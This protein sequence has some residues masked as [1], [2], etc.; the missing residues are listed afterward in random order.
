ML[1]LITAALRKPISVIVILIAIVFFSI[2]AIQKSAVDI[3][4]KLGT[5]TI[6]VAQ[7]YGGLSPQQMEGFI[8][9]YYEYHFLYITG[10]K[11]VDSKSVQGVA[12]IKLQFHEGTDMANAMA[13]V[14]SYVNRARSFM[15]PGTLPPFVMRYDAGSVPVGQLALSSETRSLNDIQDLALFKVRPMFSSLP[16]VSAPPPFGGNQRT[17]VIKA[18]PERMRSY[19]LA[20]EELITAIAKSNTIS[21]AGN[22]RVGDMTLI[23]PS[24]SVVDNFKELE[25]T[26]LKLGAGASIY[27]RDVA[28]VE[29]GAD[30]TTGYA[31]INGKRAV[32]IPVTKR[33]DASTWDVVR[34]IKKALPDMQAAV[35]PDIKVSYEFDQ[36]G[37]VINS[38]KSLL[39]EAGLGALLTGLMVFFFLGDVRSAVI[40][41]L[42]IPLALL[43]SV[44]F[45]YLGGQTINIMTLGGLAL[46][47]GI[48]VDE[49]TVT[50]ENIHRYLEMGKP[51]AR[52]VFD[53]CKEIA[54]P[55]LLILFSVLAVFVPSL[56]M[57]GV[58]RAMFLPLSLAVGF[59]M[60]SSFIL[61]QTFV[62]VI[63]N[64]ILNKEFHNNKRFEKF[65]ERFTNVSSRLTSIG[66]ILLLIYLMTTIIFSFFIYNSIGK[67]IFPKIDAGQLQL[68]LRMPSG[69]RIERTE[70]ATKKVLN[71]IDSIAGKQNV[72]ITSSFV[73]LQPQSYAINSIFLWTSG[74]HEAVLKVNLKKNGVEIEKF[75]EQLREAIKNYNAA[76]AV[77]FEPAD[78]VDQVMSF[79]TN[80]PIEVAVQGRNLSQGRLYAEKLKTELGKIS[81]LR[82]VQFGL[83][84]DYPG[85]QINYDRI[86]SGQ[87]GITVDDA[88]K[89][90]MPGTSSSRLTTPIYWLDNSSGN[91]YQVQVEYPQ[92]KMNSAEQVEQ[93]PVSDNN[94]KT[95]YLRDVADWKKINTVGEYDRLNQQRYITVTANL[96]NK[97]LGNAL[98]DVHQAIGRAGEIP[99]GMKIFLRGQSELLDQTLTELSQGLLLAI[100]VI[101]LLLAANFQSF[102]LSL[103][104]VATIPAVV[105]GSFLLLFLTG[106][107]LNIQSFM[108]SIMAIGV[109][110]A[111]AILLVT[112]AESLRK[113]NIEN[114]NIGMEAARNRL[115]PILMTNIAMV[116]GMIPMAIGLGEGSQQTT[117]LGIA[118]IGGLILSTITTLF[119]LPIIYN[120]ISGKRKFMEVS[121]D[122]NDSNSK[123]FDK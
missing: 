36:S 66:K 44:V 70:E 103:A 18:D 4:P 91:A 37:Y 52:A 100:I 73:G 121:L 55:K 72:D 81:Y 57:T 17:I 20:P 58:P 64:W 7:T 50:V 39:F 106:H 33:A 45:L 48:L 119:V 95:V 85:L 21:P 92:F 104:I 76:I 6:Y 108:G 11:F 87:M 24:N 34:R 62:P 74:P 99:Q 35:P 23:T 112:N 41:V 43:S 89:S 2:L 79:G 118:V 93:I 38:L 98:K 82:D 71:I 97:D 1:R 15:P 96:N 60:I 75:K 40:V 107:T 84:L 13:E 31:L 30:I 56:F 114:K 101:F 113:Q 63:T 51:R 116:A 26:P 90:I 5:P 94:G 10:I 83:P 19:H 9:S 25:N 16:G 78:L 14:V 67:E 123:F 49:A 69:T 111:N 59:A 28:S 109:A 65:K 122:P 27:V 53:A 54:L 80:T 88:A 115:R 86:K 105:F 68:R 22:I 29:N 120:G 61:S 3:F 8:T 32:Y 46:A 42:T 102:R 47:V 12:L 110:V 77:S 117:P